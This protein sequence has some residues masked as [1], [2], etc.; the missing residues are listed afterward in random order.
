M[1]LVAKDPQAFAGL[2]RSFQVLASRGM[3]DALAK[4]IGAAAIKQLADQ[5]KQSRDPYGNPWAPV[6]RMRKR[7]TE[8]K[9]RRSASGRFLPAD[10]PLVDTGRLRGAATAKA[11]NASSGS[12]VR[13]V[14]PVEYASYHQSGTG[15]MPRRQMIPEGSTGGLG[16]IWGKAF[17]REAERLLRETMEGRK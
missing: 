11:A 4:R 9:A 15:R 1:G 6:N 12:V 16:P 7:D 17:E 13:I 3:Q 8:A 2:Q 14:I 5:F 10:K